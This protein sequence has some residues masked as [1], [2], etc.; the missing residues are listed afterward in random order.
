VREGLAS[1]EFRDVDP[2][3]AQQVIHTMTV[4]TIAWAARCT[5]DLSS[6]SSEI[7]DFVLLGLL[8]RPR[9]LD[10]VRD[11]PGDSPDS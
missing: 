8:A 10:A 4:E 11:W 9:D 6:R 2:A 7:A 3:F 5:D 1:G